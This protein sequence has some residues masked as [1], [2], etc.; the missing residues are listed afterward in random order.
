MRFSATLK[1]S[2]GFLPLTL[3][4]CRSLF[5][6]LDIICELCQQ[7][8]RVRDLTGQPLPDMSDRIRL[9][10]NGKI[11]FLDLCGDLIVRS[12]IPGLLDKLQHDLITGSSLL[13]AC[14][15]PPFP[16]FPDRIDFLSCK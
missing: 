13:H 15:P 11:V 1:L 6:G 4:R 8:D 2:L 3:F 14:P 9:H 5:L 10:F 7:K 16:F 12:A